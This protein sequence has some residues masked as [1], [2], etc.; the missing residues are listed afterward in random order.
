MS[1][2]A[3]P[4]AAVLPASAE[5]FPALPIATELEVKESGAIIGTN[6]GVESSEPVEDVATEGAP[7]KGK[8]FLFSCL[9]F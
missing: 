1:E 2:E 3:N 5:T 4:Q 8:N 7:A 9:Q 6:N